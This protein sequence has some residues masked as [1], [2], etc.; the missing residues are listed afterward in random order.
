MASFIT[1]YLEATLEKRIE[2]EAK[3]NEQAK[4]AQELARQQDVTGLSTD[5]AIAQLKA[6]LSQQLG[7]D[8]QVIDDA[9]LEN[10]SAEERGLVDWVRREG[11]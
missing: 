2:A 11:G 10:M 4:L 7:A 6:A 3:Q 8:G 9:T 5:E 1:S